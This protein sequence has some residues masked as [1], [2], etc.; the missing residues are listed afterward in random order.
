LQQYL[1]VHTN[2]DSVLVDTIVN[3]IL[4]G[5]VQVCKLSIDANDPNGASNVNPANLPA[6]PA[7]FEQIVDSVLWSY[8]IDVFDDTT[9][10][11]PYYFCNPYSVDYPKPYQLNPPLL[12]TYNQTADSCNCVRWDSLKGAAAAVG[13]D[14][15]NMHSM[16]IYLWTNYNDSLSSPLWTGLQQCN[17]KVWDTPYVADSF[18]VRAPDEPPGDSIYA[19]NYDNVQQYIGLSADVEIPSFL[20]CGYV[21]PCVTCALIDSLTAQFRRLFPSF[22]GVPYTDSTMDT[23]EAAQN[24]LWARYMNYKTGFSLTANDYAAAYM[25]CG[26]DTAIDGNLV[27]TNRATQA[28]GGAGEPYTYMAQ[29]TVSFEDG[30]TSNPGDEFQTSLGS[31][32]PG[33]ATAMCYL[34]P[35]A[36]YVPSVDTSQSNPCASIQQQA[37]YIGQL[38]FQELQ[39]SLTTNFDSIYKA[40]CLGAQSMEVFYATYQPTEYHYTLYYYDQAGNLV[41]T[42]PPDGVIP[43]YSPTYFAQVASARAAKTDLTNGTNIE[44]LATQYR[45]NTLNQV[46]AQQTP[47]GGTSQFWYDRLGRLAVSQNAKQADS[48]AYS[49]TEYDPLGRIT[50]VGQK[51]QHTVMTQTISQ[52]TTSLAGW[53][54]DL[55][56]GS[57]K[58][59]ITRTVYDTPYVPMSGT[60]VPINGQNLR[61]RVAYTMVID[62]DNSNVPPWRAATFYSYDPHGNVDTLLQD[63]DSTSVMGLAHNRF[64]IMTYDYDLISGKVNQV[65]YQ[66]GQADAFYQQYTYDAENR[67]V[68]VSTSRDSIQW[69][70]DASYTYY[71]HGPLARVELGSLGLQGVDYAYT[72]QGWLKSINPSWLTP[73]GTAAQ[74]DSDGMSTIAYFER[75][76][77]KLNLNYFDDGTYT[78]FSPINP[79]TGYVQ[80]NHLPSGSKRNLYNGNIA[81]QAINIRQ[82]GVSNTSVDGGPMIYN[83]GYDQLNRIS[84]MDA[85]A[86]NDSLKPTASGALSDYAERYTYDPNGN[87]L[88]LGR[89]AS[90]GGGTA[91]T[92]QLTYKYRYANTTN[93]WG[94]YTPGSAPTTGVSHL[95][96]QLSS[97]QVTT[98]GTPQN[99]N[100]LASQSAF[101]YQYNEI[102]QLTA[103]SKAQISGVVWNVYGKILSLV[104]GSDSIT[105]TYDGAGNRISKKANGITTW[106]VRDAQGNVISVYTQGNPAVHG[107]SLSQTEADLY[108]SS[109]LG[110]LN[111]SVNCGSLSLPDTGS[112]VRGNKLFELTNHLGNVL[113]TISDKKI[114]HTSDNSTV[115]YYLADV[116]GANDYYSFGMEMPGRSYAAGSAGNYRYGFN[117]QE[118]TDEI[119]GAGNHTT[120]EF[121]EYDP[122]IGRRWNLDPKP[123]VGFSP[124]SVLAAN[125]V[126]YV[127]PNGADTFHFTRTIVTKE[128]LDESHRYPSIKEETTETGSIEI[129][130]GGPDV[131]LYT[132]NT[133]EYKL[134]GKVWT[135]T[136]YTTEFHPLNPNSYSGATSTSYFFGLFQNEDNDQLT[137]ARVAPKSFINY[138]IKRS[139]AN[140]GYGTNAYKT[141]LAYQSDYSLFKGLQTVEEAVVSAYGFSTGLRAISALTVESA[142]KDLFYFSAKAMERMNMPGRQVPVQILEDV[143]KNTKAYPDPGGSRALMYYEQI[144]KNGQPYNLEVL[145][146]KESNSIWHFLYSRDAMGPLNGILK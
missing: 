124:Y 44:S 79:L 45:Y 112:L 117:G 66:P 42:L 37:D 139:E 29:N 98:T 123:S 126:S 88:T 103:D 72:L 104:A 115:D 10:H 87:I 106:Y 82:I 71:R 95:T 27:L 101:N 144:F 91:P 56:N 111:L 94:E 114:Q 48:N 81:S 129:K 93:G 20:S 116:I 134:G 142:G 35:P 83:Y 16:N 122:R 65:S 53:L 77:Y 141:A 61:N 140:G 67:L 23:T 5:M 76:A 113:E 64:K 63:F 33:S 11:P 80:G 12:A 102:G 19:Y 38:L 89:N 130:K 43:N 39:D 49:Y 57:P 84:S 127:D 30:Y 138:L 132:E 21:R 3:H 58:V 55:T 107:D 9:G 125:P 146:D 105:F 137:L 46:I 118:K 40:R 14:S 69:E 135:N 47:D 25:N 18:K 85:W 24:A 74:Y 120:A 50:E 143:I 52:D 6:D 13:Y 121:W 26:Y 136:S 1:L 34:A 119:A 75:D 145:Y 99:P 8:N 17:G 4:N 28:P 62:Q 15:T 97:I 70:N 68:G 51:P 36:N 96:N 54:A 41:K 92:A 110:L 32:A 59:Q 78:D 108:G 2:A 131:F 60:S 100:E 86:A 73:S 22:N 109:R 90:S 128:V 7:S 133:L 31:T